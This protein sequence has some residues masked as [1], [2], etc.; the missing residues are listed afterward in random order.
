MN[1]KRF[2]LASLAVFAVFQL[3]DIVIHGVILSGDYR[4]NSGLWR[5][6]MESLMWIMMLASLALSFLFVYIFTRGYEGKGVLEGVRYGLLIGLL[7]M[8][9]G[10]VNQYVVYPVPF[11]L[12]VK[13]FIFGMI[14]FAIAGVVAA[15][16]Y[17]P[18]LKQ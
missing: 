14:E 4:A 15:F 3:L 2:V 1:I 11:M 18:A 7:M 13:W 12:V 6:D 17:R 8:G 10:A 9:I 5:P 16:I